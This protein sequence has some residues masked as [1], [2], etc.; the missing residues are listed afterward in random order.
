MR[1][2]IIIGGVAFVVGAASGCGI[3]Y[4]V[5]NKRA[6]RKWQAISDEEINSVKETYKLLRKEPPYDDP[7]TAL[8]AYGERLDELNYL[9]GQAEDAA[10][11]AAEEAV[12]QAEEQLV[13]AVETLEETLTEATTDELLTVNEDPDF[14]PPEERP[15]IRNIFE[16]ARRVR[17]ER[18]AVRDPD[19]FDAL[20]VGDRREPYLISED[21]FHDDA[22]EFSKITITYFEGDDTLCDD[23]EQVIYDVDNVIGRDNLHHF[24]EDSNDKDI[25]FVRN[26]KME[27]DFEVVREEGSYTKIVLGVRDYENDRPRNRK[28]RDDE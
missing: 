1:Q 7:A 8:K 5:V 4:L 3:T 10:I 18:E 19:A 13:E 20:K 23:R 21:E 22:N 12:E 14:V 2:N 15:V 28:M 27:S 17:E 25:V 9:S 11:D 24:G 26:E 6:Q 16:E